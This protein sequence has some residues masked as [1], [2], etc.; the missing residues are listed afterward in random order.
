[1]H[2]NAIYIYTYIM[3]LY[4]LTFRVY[5]VWKIRLCVIN[6]MVLYFLFFLNILQICKLFWGHGRNK[7]WQLP[8]FFLF[9]FIVFLYVSVKCRPAKV[10]YLS[11]KLIVNG[12]ISNNTYSKLSLLGFVLFNNFVW[13]VA[14][15]SSFWHT[16]NYIIY[17]DLVLV[18]QIITLFI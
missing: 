8:F 2:I 6:V 14:Y 9:E 15:L 5:N 10:L 16:F 18:V 12:N 17:S 13:W 4:R 3:F 1:M 7:N 11:S